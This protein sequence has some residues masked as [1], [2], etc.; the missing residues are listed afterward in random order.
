METQLCPSAATAKEAEAKLGALLT[1]I[2]M[3][4][5]APPQSF[6]VK[7]PSWNEGLTAIVPIQTSHIAFHF[8]KHPDRWILHNPASKCLL[9]LDIYTCG[10]LSP[11]K[12]RRVL[13]EFASYR[14]V[15][16]EYVLVNRQMSLFIDTRRRWDNRAPKSWTAWLDELTPT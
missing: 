8:W 12:I 10:S 13:E 11:E 2:S 6:Y 15:H 16:A 3:N 14:P 9:Q 1:D 5:L 4:I 7:T